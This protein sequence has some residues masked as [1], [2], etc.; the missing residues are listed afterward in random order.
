MN[1]FREA[2]NA[3]LEAGGAFTVNSEEEIK[4]RLETLLTDDKNRL[5]A[6][7]A[8]RAVVEKNRGAAKKVADRI[9]ALADA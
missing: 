2:S 5:A 9:L 7:G 1:N 8:A 6:G 4:N 3:L